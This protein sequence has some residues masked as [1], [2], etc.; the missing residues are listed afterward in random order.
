MIKFI[1]WLSSDGDV[2]KEEVANAILYKPI[3]K[4]IKQI[5]DLDTI[6]IKT[7]LIDTQTYLN[8]KDELNKLSIDPDRK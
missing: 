3:N 6:F 7:N 5:K 1:N 8:F 2:T 4:I